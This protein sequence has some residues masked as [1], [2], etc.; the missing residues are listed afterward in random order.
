[1][2]MPRDGFKYVIRFD[3]GEV[4]Q[5]VN[6]QAS[7]E[8]IAEDNE[9]DME[10]MNEEEMDEEYDE[11]LPFNVNVE[12]HRD[13]NQ[14]VLE[15][16]AEV[17]PA[18]D[19]RTYDVFLMDVH[20][21]NPVKGYTGP[22]YDTLDEELREQFDSLLNKNFKKMMPLVADYS[23]AKEANLY[24]EWLEDVKGIVSSPQ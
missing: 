10:E 22:S 20:V 17:S 1:M 16:S 9:E 8:A 19:G 11:K 5:A 6:A 2:V 3:P 13:G 4:A 7:E 15:M 12:V 18:E 23:R 14:S 21:D 24:K